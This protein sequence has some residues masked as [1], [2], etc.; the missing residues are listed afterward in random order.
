MNDKVTSPTH[1]LHI[2]TTKSTIDM[3]ILNIYPES[4]DEDKTY[5]NNKDNSFGVKKT[6]K[7]YLDICVEYPFDEFIVDKCAMMIFHKR[8]ILRPMNVRKINRNGNKQRRNIQVINNH[9][10]VS[11]FTTKKS[12]PARTI[13]GCDRDKKYV[14]IRTNLKDYTF[15]VE[16]ITIAIAMEYVLN[17]M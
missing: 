14:T 11:S 5:V 1:S 2:P 15:K 13:K 9:V 7:G 3:D 16:S 12:F 17:S 4:P 10:M 8:L 6:K